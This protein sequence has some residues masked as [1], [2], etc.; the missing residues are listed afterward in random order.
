M[1]CCCCRCCCCCCAGLR[2]SPPHFMLELG[3]RFGPPFTTLTKRRLYTKRFLARPV[4][5]FFFSAFATFGVW[6]FTFPA[7]AKLPC[8]LPIFSSCECV[9]GPGAKC[10]DKFALLFFC[11]C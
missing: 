1:S 2:M 11:L 3:P 6:F 5:D 10:L 4:S 7:R 8:T 9:H